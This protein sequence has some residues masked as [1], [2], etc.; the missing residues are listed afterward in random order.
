MIRRS[1]L[2]GFLAVAAA[3]APV[4]SAHADVPPAAPKPAKPAAPE[5]TAEQIADRVQSFY[6]RS[7]TFKAG[8]KQQ[9]RVRAYDKTIDSQGSVVFEKPGKMSW[10]YTNNG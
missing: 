8:F 5:L 6:D 1:L 2:L 10:R 4:T 7:K 3:A 9:Y